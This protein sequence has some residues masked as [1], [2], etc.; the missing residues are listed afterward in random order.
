MELIAG[1]CHHW[2]SMRMNLSALRTTAVATMLSVLAACA[3]IPPTEN[4][5]AETDDLAMVTNAA[6]QLAGHYGPDQVLVVFDIDNT[7][8]A[9]EQ[10]LGSDQWY[11]WQKNL[12]EEEPCSGMLVN[13]RF[14]VQGALYF[15]SAMRP[16]QADTAEQVSRLQ[17]AGLH[18]IALTSRGPDY[19]LQTFRE[20]RRNDISF[21]TSALPPKRGY[22][23]SFIPKGGS[24]AARYEDGVFLTAGQH[25][26]PMLKALLDK[27][28]S[29]SPTVVVMADDKAE[30][31][32]SVM[33]TFE[34]SG[35]TIHAWRYSREDANVSELNTQE[36]AA[37]WDAVRPA[38]MKIEKIFGPDN[39][40]LPAQ[41]VP[42]G[43][44]TTNP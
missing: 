19:S 15:A 39:F 38:L 34:G 26:G 11:Y 32:Q 29:G 13:D 10:G 31:L 16:T 21:W 7:L 5:L 28:S 33:E 23:E 42:E 3:S 36:A 30:N 44:E 12:H 22:P 6:L 20:L 14:K 2:Q 25:K 17:D 4:L 24:R 9:M 8:L 41:V 35:I 37:Q 43:C 1:Q 40:D 18:V 27:T